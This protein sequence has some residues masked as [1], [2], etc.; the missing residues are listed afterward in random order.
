[1]LEQI[2]NFTPMPSTWVTWW[3]AWIEFETLVTTQESEDRVRGVI[4]IINLSLEIMIGALLVH[5]I[6][7][8]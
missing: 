7:Y 1:M 3:D 8:E 2:G 6:W 4:H 5:L